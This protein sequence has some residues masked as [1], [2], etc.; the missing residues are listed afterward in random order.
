MRR[1]RTDITCSIP[2]GWYGND[3]GGGDG[4]N[5]EDGNVTVDPCKIDQALVWL[6]RRA[7]ILETSLGPYR[8]R[9]ICISYRLKAR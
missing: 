7:A 8:D 4:S 6:R 5:L 1:K 3:P 2:G 9:G